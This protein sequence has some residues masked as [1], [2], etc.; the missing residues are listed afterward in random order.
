MMRMRFSASAPCRRTATRLPGAAPPAR[1]RRSAPCCA[2][3]ARKRGIAAEPGQA[4]SGSGAA[5]HTAQGAGC[6]PA[7]GAHRQ[8]FGAG[9]GPARQIAGADVARREGAL[10]QIFEIGALAVLHVIDVPASRRGIF[11]PAREPEEPLRRFQ[12]ARLRGDHENRVDP[13]H[14]HHAHHALERALAPGLQDLLEPGRDFRHVAIAGRK[15]R[16][17]LPGEHIDVEGADQPNQALADRRVATDDQRVTPGIGGDLAALADIG[18]E[19]LGE[20]FG[21]GIAQCDH[22]SAGAGRVR[23][24]DRVGNPGGGRRHDDIEPV[25]FDQRGAVLVEHGFERRQQRRARH[26]RAGLDR[27]RAM[28]V[29]VDRKVELQHGAE[30][31]AR[32]LANIGVDEIQRDIAGLARG[33]TPLRRQ[34]RFHRASTRLERGLLTAIAGDGAVHPWLRRLQLGRRPERGQRRRAFKRGQLAGSQRR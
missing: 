31:R 33:G 5:A 7:P 6:K 14:R 11:D 24:A 21:R 10:Q 19:Q 29:G 8:R 3:G 1:R 17:G 26:R 16:K 13:R 22:L 4:G 27:C 12:I 18:F 20:V 34:R 25:F 2:G 23:P 9:C 30:N 32:D 15:E 28:H